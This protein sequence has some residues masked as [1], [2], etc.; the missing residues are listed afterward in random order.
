MLVRIGEQAFNLKE[1]IHMGRNG[2]VRFRSGE[3]AY[4]TEPDER[5]ELLDML[6]VKKKASRRKKRPAT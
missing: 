2:T 1:I 5:R 4:I 6:T 3:T